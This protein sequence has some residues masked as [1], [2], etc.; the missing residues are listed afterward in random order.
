[1][2]TTPEALPTVHLCIATG[3]NAANLIPLEQYDAREIWILQTPAM[4]ER[5]GHLAQ[6]LK[7]PDRTIVRKD[8]DDASPKTIQTSATALAM[9]L[10][11]RHVV[12]HATGGTKL[13]VLALR[14]ELR[15]LEAGNG[16]LDVLY[17]DTPRQQ[18]DW[19]GDDPRSEPMDDVL[20]LQRMLQVQGYRI[21][22]DNRHAEAQKRAQTRAAMT[23]DLGENAA[24]YARGF[25][26]LAFLAGRAESDDSVRGLTQTFS[27]APGGPLAQLL[28]K[29]Q[30]LGL[31]QWDGDIHLTFSSAEVARYFAGGWLEEFVL[32]KLTGGLSKP[33]RFSCN[34]QVASGDGVP[35]EL[36]AM[37]I[38]RNR[39]LLIECKTGRQTDKASDALYKLAQLRDRL[40]GSVASALYISAQTIGEEHLQRAAEYRIAVLHGDQVS[41]VVAHIRDWMAR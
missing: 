1:M 26:T 10:D 8:F 33:G 39:A 17:A 11:G 19:L 29:A 31:V 14:D 41:G 2:T 4:R 15:L 24:R 3:Q 9:A 18:V 21:V 36:D 25:S 38:H 7:R 37:V 30:E 27:Y 35:N 28:Q 40:G 12:L 20:D 6:A 32:L 13:M 23:R 22:G 16:R 5:A 34:L